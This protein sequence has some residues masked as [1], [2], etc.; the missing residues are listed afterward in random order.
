MQLPLFKQARGA[1]RELDVLAPEPRKKPWAWLLRRAFALVRARINGRARSTSRRAR[2]AA[3]RPAGSRRRPSQTPLRG[4]SRNMAS[5]RGRL[6]LGRHPE[7]SCGSRFQARD[8]SE[9]RGKA[10]SERARPGRTC[11]REGA[12]RTPSEPISDSQDAARAGRG[13]SSSCLG[14]EEPMPTRVLDDVHRPFLVQ[15]PHPRGGTSRRKGARQDRRLSGDHL[16]RDHVRVRCD[17]RPAGQAGAGSGPVSASSSSSDGGCAVS[18]RAA[19][20]SGVAALGVGAVVAAALACRRRRRDGSA[21]GRR[22]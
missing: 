20:T 19:G 3:A 12:K 18:T 21:H 10:R 7:G 6:L 5:A 9:R 15:N 14:V 4:C 22:A 16:R 13:A 17:V 2:G 8:R 11:V 1:G